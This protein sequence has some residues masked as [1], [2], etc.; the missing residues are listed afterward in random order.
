MSHGTLNSFSTHPI[1]KRSYKRFVRKLRTH[2][3][4]VYR[5]HVH[6]SAPAA[7]PPADICKAPWAPSPGKR[8]PRASVFSW[9]CGSLSA[10]GYAELMWWVTHGFGIVMLQSTHWSANDA[11]VTHGYAVVPSADVM[12]CL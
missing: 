4:A 8:R 9:N 10:G 12:F 7:R 5:G 2:G 3:I 1:V 6:L 11:W